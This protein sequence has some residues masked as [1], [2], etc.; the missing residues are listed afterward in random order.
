M[1]SDYMVLTLKFYTVSMPFYGIKTFLNKRALSSK[2][3]S[4]FYPKNMTSFLNYVTAMLRALFGLRA[5]LVMYL[6]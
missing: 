2:H 4:I 1:H 6:P 3:M 5:Q